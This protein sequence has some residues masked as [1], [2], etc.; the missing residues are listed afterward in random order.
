MR[1]Y[2]SIHGLKWLQTEANSCMTEIDGKWVPAR[3][4]GL[5]SIRDRFRIAWHVFT[6][7]L[8]ALRW[9]EGQ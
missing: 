7:K 1:K 5:C 3:P 8:D 4:M 6:G 2:P 9:P